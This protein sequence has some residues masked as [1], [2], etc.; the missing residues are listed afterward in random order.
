MDVHVRNFFESFVFKSYEDVKSLVEIFR[1][2][3]NKPQND[4][5][6][7]SS[8]NKTVVFSWFFFK[9]SDFLWVFQEKNVKKPLFF[10]YDPIATK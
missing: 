1:I 2:A 4:C 3:M 10:F 9:N 7:G 6:K 8:Q 5:A